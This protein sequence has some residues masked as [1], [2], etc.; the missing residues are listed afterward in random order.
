V[1]GQKFFGRVPGQTF[2]GSTGN[3]VSR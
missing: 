2:F 1:P 3:A